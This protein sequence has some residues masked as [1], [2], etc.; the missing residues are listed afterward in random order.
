MSALFNI[1]LAETEGKIID[2]EPWE[3][4]NALT[5]DIKA[6]E[7][8]RRKENEKALKELEEARKRRER[9]EGIKVFILMFL[10]VVL[11]MLVP[12]FFG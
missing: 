2:V 7:E 12:L 10:F 6:R 5:E 9:K 11:F 3:L 4:R 1:A 8:V